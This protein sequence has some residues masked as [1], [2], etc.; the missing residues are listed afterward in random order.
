MVGKLFRAVAPT[1][2]DELQ[3]AMDQWL[4]ARDSFHGESNNG[5]GVLSGF[6]EAHRRLLCAFDNGWACDDTELLC[7]AYHAFLRVLVRNRERALSP[8]N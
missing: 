7:A 2:K 1:R 8:I 5:V 6:M 3:A 4:E